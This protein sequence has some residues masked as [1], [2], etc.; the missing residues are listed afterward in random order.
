[1]AAA[2]CSEWPDCCC[3]VQ[4]LPGGSWWI[5]SPWI[6]HF[7][8][9]IVVNAIIVDIVVNGFS[10]HSE[11]VAA[12]HV[13]GF[14]KWCS[15]NSSYCS[16]F[17][18]SCLIYEVNTFLGFASYHQNRVLLKQF[19]G[20]ISLTWEGCITLSDL[21]DQFVY[22]D[23]MYP[24]CDRQCS[25]YMID[26]CHLKLRSSNPWSKVVGFKHGLLSAC[27]SVKIVLFVVNV[28]HEVPLTL[29]VFT[30]NAEIVLRSWM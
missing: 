19:S 16:Y 18:S 7:C 27:L 20:S 5:S 12:W 4:L 3:W 24:V 22:D 29:F 15:F 1:M 13:F 6:Q 2:L 30:W 9:D 10:P 28:R 11:I 17:A 25:W 26:A 23:K 21:T 8:V 14:D